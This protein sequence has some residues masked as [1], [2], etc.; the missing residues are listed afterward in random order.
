M[1]ILEE[2]VERKRKRGR[3]GAYVFYLTMV[4]LLVATF[5][6]AQR[7]AASLPVQIA[8]DPAYAPVKPASAADN[9]TAAPNDPVIVTVN[10]EAVTQ[11]EFE[12][13]MATV[14]A[15]MRG[16]LATPAGKRR[17][18]EQIVDLKLL[19][20]EAERQGI[21]ADPQMEARM[22]LERAQLLASAFLQKTIEKGGAPDLRKLYESRRDQFESLAVRQILVAFRGSPVQTRKGPPLT[23]AAAKQKAEQLAAKIRAGASFEEVARN[24]SDDDNASSGGSLGNIAR[25][26]FPPDVEEVVFKL[27][28][29]QVSPPLRT[30]YGWH[31]FKVDSRDVKSFDEVKPF[32]ERQAPA[33]I[34]E[35]LVEKLKKNAKIDYNEALLGQTAV[36]PQR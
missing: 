10:G 28:P 34:A 2:T 20:Q 30:R 5:W 31:L 25:G 21:A 9:R 35:E 32:L 27:Q 17:F 7:V 24:E 26:T 15:Q 11:S 22:S 33:L 8:S 18:A 1:T 16:V 4:V 23:D 29:G 36:A 14:P 6:W 3:T 12:S 13:A 19:A